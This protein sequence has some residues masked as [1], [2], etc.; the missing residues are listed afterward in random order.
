MLSIILIPFFWRTR[1][2]IQLY[3]AHVLR[4]VHALR[5]RCS[6][7]QIFVCP[8]I[9]FFR[10]LQTQLPCLWKWHVLF[11][12]NYSDFPKRFSE[13]D[14]IEI[15]EFLIDNIFALFGG[16]VFHHI[17]AFLWVL[18]VF[19]F[20]PSYCVT[21]KR[22]TSDRRKAKKLARSFKFTFR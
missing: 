15:L 12:K 19:P 4:F 17:L 20:S 8:F 2:P 3:H 7:L 11:C 5:F 14:I 18:T 13:T 22:H 1:L 21:C 16:C 10:S 9:Y 6:V